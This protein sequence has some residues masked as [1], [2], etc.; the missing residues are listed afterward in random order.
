M[1]EMWIAALGSGMLA[2]GA[3]RFLPVALVIPALLMWGWHRA[4]KRKRLIQDVP[5][6]KVKGVAIGLSEVK[7]KALRP[8]PFVSYLAQ[9]PTVWYRYSIDEHWRRTVTE[10]YTDSDGKRRTRTRTETG[11]TTVQSD[12]KTGRFFLEDDTG[13]IRIDPSKATVEGRSIFNQTCGRRDPLYYGK[14]PRR[15]VANSTGRRRFTEQAIVIDDSIYVLGTA[16]IRRD[17]VAAELAYDREDPLFLISVKN[18]AQVVSGYRLR[19]WLFAIFGVLLCFGIVGFTA[20]NQQHVSFGDWLAL[21]FAG[22]SV[23]IYL[24]ILVVL[25]A[26]M[27]YNGLVRVR[28]RIG[29]AWALIEVQLKRRADLIPRLAATVKGY[30]DYER[31]V[32]DALAQQ[33]AD[34]MSGRAKTP[35]KS[36]V[37][38]AQEIAD[39]QTQ[40]LTRVLAVVEDYPDLKANELYLNLQTQLADTEDRIALARSFYN[41]TVTAYNERIAMLPD[42]LFAKLM[43]LGRVPHYKIEVF[44]RRPVEVKLPSPDDVGDDSEVDAIAPGDADARADV[45][46]D[47]QHDAEAIDEEPDRA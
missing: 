10:S 3:T 18:E 35:E 24:L 7:G 30:A 25:F 5:T 37:A 46:I 29:K 13:S 34:A 21:R 28:N 8:E 27:L 38:R 32:Q 9:V 20:A 44:E 42:V 2:E 23:L 39:G 15:S 22:L 17:A 40:V 45:Q 31:E 6:S 19:A 41:D 33:R 14:G 43:A 12:L 4:A 16:R 1:N 26:V 11:W 36:E 47:A